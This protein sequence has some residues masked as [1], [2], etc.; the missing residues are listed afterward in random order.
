MSKD[1][2]I[3]CKDCGNPSIININAKCDN[4]CSVNYQCL[5]EQTD[6]VPSELCIGGGS[7]IRFSYCH[8]CMKILGKGVDCSK[9]AEALRNRRISD[10]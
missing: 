6:Y 7:Y 5:P 4:K 8:S 9:V 10:S 2:V 1:P 3:K